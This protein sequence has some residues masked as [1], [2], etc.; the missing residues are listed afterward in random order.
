MPRRRGKQH[1]CRPCSLP[2][3]RRLGYAASMNTADGMNTTDITS[4]IVFDDVSFV[5]PTDGDG[6]MSTDGAAAAAVAAAPG[7]APTP[8]AAP[9]APPEQVFG[10]LSLQIPSGV[11]SLVGPNGVGKSTFLLLAGARLFPT[12]GVVT[13]FGRDTRE[14]AP[15]ASGAGAAAGTGASAAADAATSPGAAV[16]TAPAAEIDPD[17]ES[18]R[19]ELVSFVYQNMEFETEQPLGELL[20][21]VYEAG[22]WENKSAAFT[23]ELIDLLEL[24]PE[25]GKRTGELSKGGMQRA[26]IAFSLLYGS[27]IIA[28]DEPVFAL[29][30]NQKQ[31]V[32]EYLVD[33]AARFSRTVLFSA[34]E[35]TITESYSDNMLLF[36][37]DG[38]LVFGPTDEVLTREAVERAY[39]VPYDLLH[40]KEQLYREMLRGGDV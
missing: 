31:R 37:K 26:V 24:G 21:L 10:G 25:L 7:A 13:I 28:M 18:E 20:D 5:Y 2:R 22:I 40:R 27:R 34:H 33:I 4:P 29:E 11:T 14:F 3:R 39:Q 19:N 9:D 35:L 6:A 30:E 16:N 32:F 8:D 12:E 17:L 15:G 38:S 23:R 1:C 36:G